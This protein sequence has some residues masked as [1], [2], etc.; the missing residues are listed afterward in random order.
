MLMTTVTN[1]QDQHIKTSVVTQ[2][3]GFIHL[4]SSVSKVRP[5][6]GHNISLRHH[7]GLTD[8]LTHHVFHFS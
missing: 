7:R 4:T 8:A 6:P 2:R 5:G 1:D 3:L